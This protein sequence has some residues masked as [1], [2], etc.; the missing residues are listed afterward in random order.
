MKQL[1][2]SHTNKSIDSNFRNLYNYKSENQNDRK[3]ENSEVFDSPK[4]SIF[5][6][7]AMFN[8]LRTGNFEEVTGFNILKPSV[9][10]LDNFFEKYFEDHIESFNFSKTKRVFSSKE[11]KL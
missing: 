10:A 11:M 7:E 6:G 3:F 5:Q 8:I 9:A 1:H 4:K 2:L